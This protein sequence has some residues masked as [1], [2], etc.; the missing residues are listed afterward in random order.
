[1]GGHLEDIKLWA[2]NTALIS[3]SFTNIETDLKIISLLL[4][5]GYTC[6]RWYLMEKNKNK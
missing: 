3:L 5:I 1:M 4:A 6:R 2:I